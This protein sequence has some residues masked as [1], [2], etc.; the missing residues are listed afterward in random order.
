M[1]RHWVQKTY[2]DDR[3]KYRPYS[4]TSDQY[5]TTRFLNKHQALSFMFAEAERDYKLKVIEISM[6][7]P[8]GMSNLCLEEPYGDVA[9]YDHEKTLAF[10]KWKLG[11]MAN[12][13]EEYDRA[14]DEKFEETINTHNTNQGE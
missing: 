3:K 1:G 14:I 8:E 11:A 9:P 10:Y 2:A 7:F 12:G 5:L 6:I 13:S 4:S